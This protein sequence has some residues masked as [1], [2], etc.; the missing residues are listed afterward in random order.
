MSRQP[1]TILVLG[2]IRSGKSEF[3]ESLV[4]EA[5]NVRY[6]ATAAEPYADAE[7]AAR[8]ERHRDRR[9][10]GWSTE[11]IGKAPEDLAALI[12]AAGADDTILVD[13]IGGWLT[14]LL[15]V[16]T[17]DRAAAEPVVTDANRIDGTT[18]ET[19]SG[20]VEVVEHTA[21]RSIARSRSSSR[22]RKSVS[23]SAS[24]LTATVE[25]LSVAVGTTSAHIVFVTPEVGMSVVPATPLG[26]A[27]AD[28]CGSVNRALAEVCDAVALVVAGQPTWIKVTD[29][30]LPDN[31]VVAPTVPARSRPTVPVSV[32]DLA[33]LDEDPIS[34]G[35][36]L[37]LPDTA[38]T[39]AAT[40]RAEGLPLPGAGF[41]AVTDAIGFAAGVQ[42]NDVPV[43][44]GS[45]R[46]VLI[47]G[48]HRGSIASGD[49]PETW[50]DRLA[51]I[52][53][54]DS[55]LSRLASEVGAP[56]EIIDAGE[57]APIED[58]PASTVDEI[59]VALRRGWAAANAAADRGDD[60]IVFAAGGSGV[61][62]AAAAV[63]AAMTTN[64]V[65]AL[66]GRVWDARGRLD[67]A[68]WMRRC[69]VVRDALLRLR[70]VNG[71]ACD[72]PTALAAVGG[73]TLATATGLLLG[74]AARRTPVLLDGPVGTAAALLARDYAAQTRMW[75]LLTDLGN[76]PTVRTAADMLGLA[77]LVD[78]RLG[79]GE[80]CNALAILPL[81]QSALAISS[82]L[83]GS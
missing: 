38:A 81:I 33:D 66:I 42:A 16:A 8:V 4:A 39:T 55:P 74:S 22:G 72:A 62:A 44:F 30:R 50:A 18:T 12:S 63:V 58:G 15:G 67:D 56:V 5:T 76:Q 29:G 47:H 77:P 1:R 36:S 80:G 52:R 31:V 20:G 26:R 37:P 3:A 82:S 64:E 24:D 57:A 60:L 48:E 2:G 32:F 27:F 65:P 28:A 46:V 45:V 73:P 6:V 7:W 11:E 34:I 49:D 69:V 21:S 35:M 25:A 10:G 79:L 13:D 51:A 19:S 14:A 17:D 54:G 68:A 43:P 70:G 78:L 40:E 59:A 53:A 61:D 9:P 75:C 71:P 41:G 23:R 83:A